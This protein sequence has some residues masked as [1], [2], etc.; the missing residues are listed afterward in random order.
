MQ[1]EGVS[2][3][4][5]LGLGTA[6]DTDDAVSTLFRHRAD[7]SGAGASLVTTFSSDESRCMMCMHDAHA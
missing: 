3:A 4:G 1:Q 5:C 2:I 7:E 6:A